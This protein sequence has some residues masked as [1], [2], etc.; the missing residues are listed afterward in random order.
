MLLP[1]VV[2]AGAAA[3]S[4]ELRHAQ[5]CCRRQAGQHPAL[6]STRAAQRSTARSALLCPHAACAALACPRRRCGPCK[7]ILPT[8]QQWAEELEGRCD[9]VKFNCNKANKE[10]GVKVAAC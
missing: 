10:L 2:T 4:C 1:A 7:M 8:L 5:R 9:I 3:R 6:A